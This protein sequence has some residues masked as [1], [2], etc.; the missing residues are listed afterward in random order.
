MTTCDFRQQLLPH[1]EAPFER[2][3][4]ASVA[5]GIVVGLHE[6]YFLTSPH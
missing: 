2:L 6:R 3:R 4:L 1:E 5:T